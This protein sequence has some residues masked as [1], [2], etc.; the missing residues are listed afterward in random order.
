MSG[1]VTIGQA[2]DYE[3]CCCSRVFGFCSE[4]GGFNITSLIFLHRL[5]VS[6][7]L[8]LYIDEVPGAKEGLVEFSPVVS[9]TGTQ[10]AEDVRTGFFQLQLYTV[11]CQ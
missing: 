10:S 3:M 4:L 9:D 6:P 11:S 7:G 1:E 5:F 2:S 8:F